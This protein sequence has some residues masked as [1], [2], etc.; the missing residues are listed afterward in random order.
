[1]MELSFK[2]L[3]KRI[4]RVG[5]SFGNKLRKGADV[6]EW[7]INRKINNID[8]SS[9]ISLMNSLIS[10]IKGSMQQETTQKVQM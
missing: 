1:M 10:Q 3:E 4:N 2:G 5:K 8:N 9:L 7:N 6:L